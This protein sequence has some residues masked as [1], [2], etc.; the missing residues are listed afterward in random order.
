MLAFRSRDSLAQALRSPISNRSGIGQRLVPIRLGVFFLISCTVLSHAQV[1]HTQ[2][3][4]LQAGWK[5]LIL[6]R[7]LRIRQSMLSPHMS[8]QRAVRSLLRIPRRIFLRPLVGPSGMP[9]SA[10]SRSLHRYT[11]S[12]AVNPIW[13]MQRAM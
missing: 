9:R 11:P 8:L 1:L 3:V 2:E 6:R 12:T 10:A 4:S 13:Y 7:Y 5:H